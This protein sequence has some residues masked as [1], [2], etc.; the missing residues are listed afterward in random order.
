MIDT[1]ERERIRKEVLSF[2][3][4]YDRKEGEIP[5]ISIILERVKTNRANLYGVFPGG[6]GEMCRLAGIPSTVPIPSGSPSR[7]EI[8]QSVPDSAIAVQPKTENT[9]YPPSMLLLSP[10]Q[11]QRI[12]TISHLEK[13]K[14]PMQIVN[15]LLDSD[16]TR[17]SMFPELLLI[18]KARR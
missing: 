12:Y 9:S 8:Q 2:Y 13:G 16:A 5:S 17:R 18:M 3:T 6:Q 4:Q 1:I 15:E 7:M 11:T 14:D 10:E